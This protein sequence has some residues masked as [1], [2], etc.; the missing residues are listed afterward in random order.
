MERKREQGG[1]TAPRAMPNKT[2]QPQT[3]WER[4]PRTMK[5]VAASPID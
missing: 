3:E 1:S 4:V 5:I 2:V